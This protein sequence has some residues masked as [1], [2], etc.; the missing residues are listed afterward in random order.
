MQKLTHMSFVLSQLLSYEILSNQNYQNLQILQN[1]SRIATFLTWAQSFRRSGK[2][3]IIVD[4]VPV[5]R[6]P[7]HV[8]GWWQGVDITLIIIYHL[9]CNH[10][11]C[12]Y[13]LTLALA[14]AISS[15][16]YDVCCA[17]WQWVYRRHNEIKGSVYSPVSAAKSVRR[18][19]GSVKWF[20]RV[21]LLYSSYW[22]RSIAEFNAL[23]MWGG[24][25]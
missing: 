14:M 1:S 4:V 19:S 8:C 9:S 18:S 12:R 24:A 2:V 5:P 11:R 22:S 15:T 3:V 13:R 10:R 17:S 6:T 25:P 20:N 21:V 16:H 7:R 23:I